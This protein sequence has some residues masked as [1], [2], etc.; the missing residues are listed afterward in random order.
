MSVSLSEYECKRIYYDTYMHIY[1]CGRMCVCVCVYG[2]KERET[3]RE[4]EKDV[5]IHF[6]KC[7]SMCIVYTCTCVFLFV[8]KY[9]CEKNIGTGVDNILCTL[10]LT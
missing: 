7:M 1:I 4:R 10:R 6:Y 8:F 5:Y 3:E 2:E 9:I